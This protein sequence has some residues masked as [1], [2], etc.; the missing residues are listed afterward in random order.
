MSRTW[1]THSILPF[2]H[3]TNYFHR[4]SH[5]HLPTATSSAIAKP[6]VIS[7]ALVLT[8]IHGIAMAAAVFPRVNSRLGRD[9]ENG[10]ML[11]AQNHDNG[12]QS[13]QASDPECAPRGHGQSTYSKSTFGI[14]ADKSLQDAIQQ[15][16]A[17]TVSFATLS[18]AA[19]LLKKQSLSSR[20][21]TRAVMMDW[22]FDEKTCLLTVTES[23]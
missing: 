21:Y 20:R 2:K 7:T 18:T 14:K 15:K 16:T 11:A 1:P 22:I 5:S 4:V 23:G 10:H 9:H 6:K 12:I 17:V 3:R 19:Y 13:T 8:V